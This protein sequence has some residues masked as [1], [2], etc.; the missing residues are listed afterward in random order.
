MQHENK[1]MTSSDA[2]DEKDKD[3]ENTDSNEIQ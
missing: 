3:S 2:F 1:G